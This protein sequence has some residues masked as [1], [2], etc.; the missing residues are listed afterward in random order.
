M[1]GL[2]LGLHWMGKKPE[3]IVTSPPYNIG[4]KY[5]QYDDNRPEPEYMDWISDWFQTVLYM[6]DEQGS[7]FIVIGGRPVDPL[8][9]L[10]VI[11]VLS[12]Q[13]VVQNVI[14][15]VKSTTLD[16][17]ENQISL[18]HYKPINSTRFV[19]DCHEYVFHLTK[20]GNVPIDRLAVGVPYADPSNTRRW[21]S[22]ADGLRCRGNVWVI[23]YRTIQSKR[24]RQYHPATFPVELAERCIKLH[25][26]KR[27]MMVADPFMGIGTTGVAA[28]RLG[29]QFLG[30]EIDRAYF[31]AACT[32]IAEYA[33][34]S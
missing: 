22:G 25:G 24:H 15:W 14:H 23:P 31:N 18:G 12:Q 11:E 4:T 26:A 32:N 7:V 8:F 9:P 30:V 16:L 13:A 21:R 33:P 29:C 27:N 34:T 3:V 20:D 17:P 19:C 10:R 1:D 5:S 2:T 28:L 6:L